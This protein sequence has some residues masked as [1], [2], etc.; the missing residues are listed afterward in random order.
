LTK[1]Q[2]ETTRTRSGERFRK[3]QCQRSGENGESPS[4]EEGDEIEKAF[5][6]DDGKQP[7]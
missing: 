7:A 1:G 4:R 6:I 3:A 5:F 2:D